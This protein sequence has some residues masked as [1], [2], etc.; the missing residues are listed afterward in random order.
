MYLK[1]VAGLAHF[2]A[3]GEKPSD[4]LAKFLV[5][6]TFAELS[7]TALYIAELSDDGY[8]SPIAGFGFDKLTIAQWGRFPLSMHLPITECVRKDECIIVRSVDDFFTFYPITREIENINTDWEAVM[9]FPML[10]YGVGFA[11]LDK[12][13]DESDDLVY[14]VRAVGAMIALHFL[15]VPVYEGS[16]PKKDKK[17]TGTQTLDLTERQKVVHQL[18]LKGFTNA[19]IAT[20]LGYSE[21]LIR[22]ETIQI[23]RVLGVSGRKEIIESPPPARRQTSGLTSYSG[24]RPCRSKPKVSASSSAMAD[25]A[26]TFS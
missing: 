11:I 26:M 1:R 21:S 14:F 7:P 13:P 23:F 20:E 9:A 24:F 22:Q 17:A 16:R 19:Q 8:L 3:E 12:Q 5:L 6:K 10:P 4:E 25:A 2:L 15:K 18:M